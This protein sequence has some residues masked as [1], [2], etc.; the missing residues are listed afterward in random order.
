MI[1]A[2]LTANL[3]SLLLGLGLLSQG[4]PWWENYDSSDTYLCPQLGRVVV[5]R[6]EAQASLLAGGTRSTGF[7]DNAD[8]PGLRYSNERLTLILRGDLLTIEQRPSRIEC[9]RTERV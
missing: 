1:T 2:T 5:E 4:S 9:T 6:N 3:P 7:R 8:L